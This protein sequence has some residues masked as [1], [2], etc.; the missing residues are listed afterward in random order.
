MKH[1]NRLLL[2]AFLALSTVP[3]A[4]RADI[5]VMKDGKKYE[6]AKIISETPD[7]VTFSYVFMKKFP[8]KRTE[9][10]S[11]IAQI[12]TQK[13]EETEVQPLLKMVP[14]PDLLTADKYESMIQDTLRPFVTKYPGT[15]QAKQ[16]EDIIKT[17]QGEKEKVV[18]GS[19]KMEGEWISADMVKR[20]AHSIEA[21]R[22]RR[23]MKALGAEG[24][25]R[26]ALAEWDKLANP[27]EGFTDTLQ[28]VK[29]VPEALTILDAYHKQ[30]D[31]MA[32]AQPGLDARRK[33]SVSKMI[34]SDPIKARTQNAIKAELEEFKAKQAVERNLRWRSVYKFDLKSIQD[35]LKVVIDETAK[36][37]ALDLAKITTQNEAL[38]AATRFIAA[39]NAEE[40][41]AALKRANSVTGLRVTNK[42]IQDLNK[43]LAALKKEQADKL[44]AKRTYNGSNMGAVTGNGTGTGP[45]ADSRV[46]ETLAKVEKEKAEKAEK[47]ASG[48]TAEK[49]EKPEKSST[50]KKTTTKSE[51]GEPK[52]HASAAPPPED[53]GFQ[54]YL[55]PAGG[56]LLAILLAV[57]YFQKK[58]KG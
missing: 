18:G 21:Y 41:D 9:P 44:K 55:L 20:D 16:V 52:H 11:A 27:T 4:L 28:Y 46:A 13:P 36:L 19:L 45:A 26:E 37:R 35:A 23:D 34:D 5:V 24:K 56:G 7:T 51:N 48:E 6:E 8:D 12:I 2:G 31:A 10:R 25:Y 50:K 29:A 39:G 58:K 33:E 32:Q 22:V 40:A 1:C 30:L 57:F 49:P 43:Q 54:K 47:K 14:T 42:A 53:E 15:P 38:V 3:S 17:L